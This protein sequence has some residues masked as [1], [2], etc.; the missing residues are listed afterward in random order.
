MTQRLADY[1][2]AGTRAETGTNVK[3]TTRMPADQIIPGSRGLP[4]AEMTTAARTAFLGRVYRFRGARADTPAHP[5]VTRTL[6]PAAAFPA[7]PHFQ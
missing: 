1:W 2:H 7:A 3:G 5:T 4:S 6:L